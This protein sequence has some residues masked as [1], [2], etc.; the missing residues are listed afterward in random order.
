[1]KP[2]FRRLSWLLM[3]AAVIVSLGVLAAPAPIQAAATCTPQA[4]LSA[5]VSDPNAAFDTAAH[6]IASF[7]FARQ[8][9]GCNVPLTIDPATYD[10]ASSQ[11]QM[12]LL[13][14]AERQ[15]RGLGALQLDASLLSQI[16][17]NHGREL[18]QLRVA[19]RKQCF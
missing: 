17:L 15:D 5:D 2:I 11:Q 1:M 18:F 4:T 10:A 14:N 19:N 12:L 9:E 6:V 16:Q 3:S 13:L 7:N 8:Q